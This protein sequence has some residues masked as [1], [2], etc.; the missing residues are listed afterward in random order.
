[1]AVLL[2]HIYSIINNK[3]DAKDNER[4]F[5]FIEFIKEFG[6]DNSTS[7]FINDYKTYLLEYGFT[8]KSDLDD[9]DIVFEMDEKRIEISQVV[10]SVSL[11]LVYFS[12]IHQ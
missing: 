4:A 7:S 11:V 3:R 10:S 1:M 6:Y 8:M 9:K 12:L 5:T 2:K